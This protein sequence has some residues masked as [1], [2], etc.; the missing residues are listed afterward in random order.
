MPI[1]RLVRHSALAAS[2]AVLAACGGDH[3]HEDVTVASA[4]VEVLSAGGAV[5]Q[6]VTVTPSGVTGGPL[7]LSQGVATTLN[8]VWLNAAGAPDQV[9]TDVNFQVRF[10]PPT[11]TGLS[12]ALASGQRNR[13]TMTGTTVRAA[14]NVAMSLFHVAEGHSDFDATLPVQVVP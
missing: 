4:R 5:V 2:V 11:G 6:T 1:A 14:T 9:M 13:G 8:I 10:T 7:L 3:N 12:W